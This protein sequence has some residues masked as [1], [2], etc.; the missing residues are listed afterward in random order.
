MNTLNKLAMAA[1]LVTMLA[2]CETVQEEQST[3]K[4]QVQRILEPTPESDEQNPIA[5]ALG[6][7][8]MDLAEAAFAE[9]EEV[10]LTADETS[11]VISTVTQATFTVLAEP[12]IEPEEELFKQEINDESALR[13]VIRMGVEGALEPDW[14]QILGNKVKIEQMKWGEIASS[15]L[16][17]WAAKEVLF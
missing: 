11:S 7:I 15:P 4:N 8:A 10:E 6:T 13:G 12:N 14:T 9:E 5:S 1:G 17:W 2:G 16:A 3:T